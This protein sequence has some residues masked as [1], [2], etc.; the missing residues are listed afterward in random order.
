MLWRYPVPHFDNYCRTQ[1]LDFQS[2][3]FANLWHVSSDQVLQPIPMLIVSRYHSKE[4]T[5]HQLQYSR[6]MPLLSLSKVKYTF[7]ELRKLFTTHT[8]PSWAISR[9]FINN[10]RFCSC[11]VHLKRGDRFLSYA[12]HARCHFFSSLI[13]AWEINASNRTLKIDFHFY[14][15]FL[16][17]KAERPSNICKY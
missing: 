6:E 10:F 16:R 4:P 17:F 14:I 11:F 1:F 7:L 12:D 5:S 15:Q 2:S 13:N 9:D 3:F 8:A